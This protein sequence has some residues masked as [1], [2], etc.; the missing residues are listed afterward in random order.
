MQ[1]AIRN[2]LKTRGIDPLGLRKNS[3]PPVKIAISGISGVT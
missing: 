1:A 3:S 2:C